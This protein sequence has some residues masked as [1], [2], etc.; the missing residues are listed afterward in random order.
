MDMHPTCSA[1]EVA[2]TLKQYF[3]KIK[4]LLSAMFCSAKC[5]TGT[6]SATEDLIPE[7]P[8]MLC[9]FRACNFDH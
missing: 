7:N 2:K 3:W 4:Y 1:T 8:F 6:Y 9:F 5:S